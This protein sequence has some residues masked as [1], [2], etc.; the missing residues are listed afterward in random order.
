MAILKG[1][2]IGGGGDVPEA[3]IEALYTAVTEYDWTADRRQVILVTDAPPHPDPR[4]K[5]LFDDFLREARARH[6]EGDAIIE[7]KDLLKAKPSLGE[8]P[9]ELS[10]LS[11]LAAAGK[12]VRLLVLPQSLQASI[13]ASPPP[14][15]SPGIEVLSPE[16]T[17]LAPG[18]EVDKAQALKA[19]IAAGASHVIFSR[20]LT[21]RRLY[22]KGNSPPSSYP[23]AQRLA[24][25]VAWSAQSAGTSA[26]FI[27]GT[28]VK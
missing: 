28:R 17:G 19:G 2:K 14:G 12:A 7:P 5:L 16:G 6:I 21:E 27:D 26:L 13:L 22:G 18:A 4:G 20:T 23:E 9:N 11:A 8:L 24:H 3:Q 15:L 25:D 10:R 1:A